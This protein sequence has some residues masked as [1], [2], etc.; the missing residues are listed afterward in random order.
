MNLLAC[1]TTFIFHI[2]CIPTSGFRYPDLPMSEFAD[3]PNLSPSHSVVFYGICRIQLGLGRRWVSDRQA[4][5]RVV[6]IGVATKF[7]TAYERNP[8]MK[9]KTTHC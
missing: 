2:D 5:A 9:G 7:P 1:A 6:V 3:T 8:R 4:I